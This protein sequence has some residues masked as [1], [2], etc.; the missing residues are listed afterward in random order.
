M[1]DMT[2]LEELLQVA[3][4]KTAAVK[5]SNVLAQMEEV[6]VKLEEASNMKDAKERDRVTEIL[7]A[8]MDQLR[9]AAL[10]EEKDLAE[11]VL[12]LNVFI[13]GL[14]GSYDD[15]TQL[16]PA[17]KAL[18]DQAQQRLKDAEDE[19][20]AVQ[21]SWNPLFKESKIQNAE[22][23]IKKAK[24]A[25]EAAQVEAKKQMRKR[26]LSASM[27][28]SLQEFQRRVAKTVDIMKARLQ[29]IQK[30]VKAVE[31][32][33]ALAFQEKERQAGFLQQAEE[34]V[35]EVEAELYQAEQERDSLPNGK[36]EYVAQEQV[37]SGLKSRL[38]DAKTARDVALGVFQSKEKFAKELEVHE[39]AQKKLRGNQIVW[40]RTLESDTEE[41]IITFRSRLEAMKASS[42]QEIAQALDN[43]GAEVDQSN[44][45]F[46]AKTAVA[47]DR[48]MADKVGAHPERLRK[49]QEAQDGLTQH[50]AKADADMKAMVASMT[51]KY[52]ID[53][54]KSNFSH[55]AK[56]PE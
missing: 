39:Q 27:E 45:D 51:E 34:A 36:S 33:K 15:L 53:P 56:N 5:D 44:V 3:D 25:I 49:M 11:A 2:Q 22:A 32:R 10:V 43:L 19:L 38:E 50:L 1:V 52:G 40:I 48:I 31:A 28:D 16:S 14:G 54:I 20:L 12:G 8:R 7:E 23:A 46:M 42:D 9:K 6:Q 47:S 35:S 17:E 13:E 21:G 37:V 4:T 24:A 55:W 41:R 29:E 30:Q 18:I 26:L